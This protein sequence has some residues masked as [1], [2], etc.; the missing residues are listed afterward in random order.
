[1][2]APPGTIANGVLPAASAARGLTGF[3]MVD[4]LLRRA[5][6][7]AAASASIAASEGGNTG[8]SI[9][10]YDADRTPFIFVEFLC[11]AWG[12]RRVGRRPR[13]QRQPH[14]EHV[15]AAGRDLAR[16]SSRWRSSRTE[17]IQDVGGP[18]KYRGGASIRRDYR[19]LEDEAVLQVRADRHDFRPYGLYGGSPGQ[20]VAQ[21][22][23][24]GHRGAGAARQGHD[25]DE[26][27]RR[28]PSRVGRGRA[29]GAI[30]S[31]ASRRACRATSGTSS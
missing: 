16:P 18:G 8:I 13:R 10:G 23:E 14:G 19:L 15:A 20:P 17:F 1:M 12:G 4:T 27:R 31:S 30:R 7:D 5:R 24:P 11:S 3:R 6:A 28:L 2:I 9:G 26:A 29:A 21:R 25:D 22:A